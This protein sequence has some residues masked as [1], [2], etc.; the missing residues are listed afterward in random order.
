MSPAPCSDTRHDM[1]H[2]LQP[3]AGEGR[4]AAAGP[5]G[6]AGQC[7]VKRRVVIMWLNMPPI[8]RSIAAPSLP[9]PPPPLNLQLDQAGNHN[10]DGPPFRSSIYCLLQA[11]DIAGCVAQ[12]LSS[13]LFSFVTWQPPPMKADL[14]SYYIYL[15][16][17]MF[18]VKVEKFLCLCA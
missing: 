11:H 7:R 4:V 17:Y 16:I 8:W 14:K 5:R 10:E 15:P 12:L 6:G 1:T 3:A 13:T 18:S 9:L 2:Y